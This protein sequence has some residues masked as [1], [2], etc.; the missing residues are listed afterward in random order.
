[1][2]DYYPV[3]DLMSERLAA[4][5]TGAATRESPMSVTSTYLTLCIGDFQEPETVCRQRDLSIETGE[6]AQ[7]NLISL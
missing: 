2:L 3:L 1:M 6:T 5:F 4:R 7:S